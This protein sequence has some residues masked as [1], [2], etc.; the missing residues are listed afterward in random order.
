LRF[1]KPGSLYVY[2]SS[3]FHWRRTALLFA[4]G[5]MVRILLPY[6]MGPLRIAAV[7]ARN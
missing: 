6:F 2:F 4:A 3:A 1:H 7:A 5:N